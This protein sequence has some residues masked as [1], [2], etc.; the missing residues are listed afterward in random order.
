MSPRPNH[1]ARLFFRVVI[2][3]AV[4]LCFAFLAWSQGATG[5]ITGTVTDP[6]G[7]LVDG[8]AVMATNTGT[9]IQKKTTTGST[10]LYSFVELPPG[11]YAIT[12]D[13]PGFAKT[14][15]SQQRLIV[16]S[17]LRLD[18]ILQ[19]GAVTES[20]TVDAAASQVNVEDAQL[21]RSLTDIPSLPLLSTN[22]GRNALSLVGLQPGVTLTPGT[23]AQTPGAVIGDFEVN[24]QRSQANNFILDGADS[25]DLAINVP[26]SVNVISPNALGEFR[27][28]TGA[29]K[30]EYGRN[31]GAVIESTIKS[32]T[33]AFHG[34][35]TEIFRNK[36][37]N[38]NNFFQ[39][40]SS[41]PRP[42]FNLNDFDANVGG[43]I[44]RD[45]TFFFASYLGFRRVFGVTNSGTVFSDQERT[46]ILANG[47]PAA[48]AI[49]NITPRASQGDVLF[50]A[51]KDKFN[52]DQGLFKIDHRFSNANNFSASYFTER[53]TEN[54][55]FS[56]GGPT[57][58]GF[59]ELDFTTYHN[60]ALHDT[61]TFSPALV[62]QAVAA[63]H[64]RDQPATF[65]ANHATPASLGFSG[66]IPD[67]PAGAGPP[68]IL[69]NSINIGNTYQGPQTRRDNTWQYGDSVSWIRGRHSIKFGVEFKAYEQNQIFDFINNGYLLFSGDFTN[70]GAIPTIPGLQGDP[71]AAAINDFAHGAVIF[72]DQANAAK[73]GLRDKFFS[74]FVQDDFKI[75]R[76]FT[77]NIGLR[78]DY[79]APLTELRNRV[80][81]FR[82]GEQSAVFPT[83]PVGLVFPGDKGISASTYSPD[84]NNFGPRIGFA[85]D[86]T[87]KGKLSL[88]TGFGVF[89]NTSESELALQFL[90]A[91]PYGVQVVALGVT[92]MTHPYQTSSAPLAQNPFPFTPAK[93]GDKFDFTSVAPVGITFMDPKFATPYA[94]QYDFQVQ[95]QIAKDWVADAA[96]VGSQGRK[97]ENRRDIN[98]GL[99]SPT[100]TTADD[101]P[102]GP[103]NLN[104]PQDAAF[105]GAVFGGLS[106]QLTDA[107][108]SYNS[109]QLSLEKRT[110]YGLT[111]TNAYTYAHCIDDA[112]GLRVN[113]NPFSSKYDRSN[114]DTDVRHRYVGSV[115][116]QLPFFRDQHGFLGHL[117]GGFSIA[118]VVSLQTG[119]PFDIVDSGDRSL[120]GAGDDRPDYIGGNVKFADPRSNSFGKANSYFDGTGGGTADGAGNPNFRR[121]GSGGSAALGAGRYGTL[122]RNVFHGPGIL[123]TDMSFSKQTRIT[124][125][126]S[127]MFRAEAFNFINHGQFFN[128][129]NSAGLN[130]IA[131]PTFGRVIFARDPRLVQ[132]SLHYTF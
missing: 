67:D 43:R 10:G 15:L 130:D 27:V 34:E 71:N 113:S 40:A 106:A 13:A 131:S 108:S 29:M 45:R 35:A 120:T 7:A 103:Y 22:G 24:G 129:G 78:Y 68:Y 62:N 73:Q 26:D 64:R 61:H 127:L 37:L 11:M 101:F 100:A 122:G 25:N 1:S 123:N 77:M 55:P 2:L 88:R 126:Q 3:G 36:V 75:A 19:V 85:W 52:R 42:P 82:A 86:P 8:A 30:A 18:V 59:G 98:P 124:E 54:N 115:I 57:I 90:G 74:A 4:A 17:N 119:L 28:V 95:Y 6:S 116:Y 76:N 72:Y 14:T 16:A 104:N 87:G 51:P 105:G 111:L 114:C 79:G 99:Y 49:V 38:A 89:Y 125:H 33:N 94:F 46:A 80:N 9:G 65:P 53:A 132:L 83:A 118:S 93:R 128:P 44:I 110:S 97:L 117:L 63:F 48:Q 81:T 5:T 84:R 112:S 121:I 70:G 109:L 12:V 39:N 50:S 102:R 56:F 23:A 92:D 20:V 66:V 60:V 31:S 47:V 41:N 32:G 69:I 107:N 21:G 58:P 91:A 96:Y